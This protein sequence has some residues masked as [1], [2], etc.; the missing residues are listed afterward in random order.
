VEAERW[1]NLDRALRDNAD[2]GAG[3]VDLRPGAPGEDQELRRLMV[4]RATKLERL[5]LAEQVA[6]ACWTLRASMTS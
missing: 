2:A 3:I 5:G 4:A 6:P 1:T